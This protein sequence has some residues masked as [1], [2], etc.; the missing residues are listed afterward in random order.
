MREKK[1]A[2]DSSIGFVYRCLLQPHQ[3]SK[4]CAVTGGNDVIAQI[5]NRNG[6]AYLWDSRRLRAGLA[7]M[8]LDWDRPAYPTSAMSATQPVTVTFE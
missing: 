1:A 6:C 7:E 4:K 2:M 8:S 5:T 3:Q